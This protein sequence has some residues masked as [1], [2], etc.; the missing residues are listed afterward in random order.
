MVNSRLGDETIRPVGT[1]SIGVEPGLFVCGYSTS[2]VYKSTDNGDTWDEGVLIPSSSVSG[3]CLLANG[4]LLACGGLATGKVYKSTDNG[5]TWDAGTTVGT[6]LSSIIQL[7]DGSVVTSSRSSNRIF[8]STDNGAT[9]GAGVWLVGTSLRQVLQ[10]DDGSVVVTAS[11][12]GKIHKSLDNGD[13]WD[14]GVSVG[15]SLNGVCQLPNGDLLCS[16]AEVVY[17]STDYGATW[18]AGTAAAGVN[19]RLYYSNRFVYASS[20]ASGT[21]RSADYGATWSSIGATTSTETVDFVRLRLSI[22]VPSTATGVLM[23]CSESD[24]EITWSTDTTNKGFK[25]CNRMKPL[26][27]RFDPTQTTELYISL[28]A[29]E[30]VKYLFFN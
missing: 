4:W 3:I 1:Q 29:G 6:Y 11:T 9:W 25:L 30:K 27:L 2:K 18:D 13:T 19:N 26:N 15:A 22:V 10:L 8:K 7:A 21:Y 24:S 14:N 5:A 23:Q 12:S 17:K 28:N 16:G 20:L